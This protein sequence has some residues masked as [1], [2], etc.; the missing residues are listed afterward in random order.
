MRLVML[1]DTHTMHDQVK[2]P[3]GDVI[4][5]AGDLTYAGKRSQWVSALEWLGNLPHK[6][7]IYI[8]GNHDF[9][10]DHFC[11]S[12]G[13]IYYLNN[14]GVTI[15]GHTFWGS[16]I[17]PTFGRWAHMCD[18]EIIDE[19]WDMIPANTEV[20]ITHGPPWGM[21]DESGLPYSRGHL[22]CETLHDAVF[23]RVRP[24]I[25]VF[26]H[27]HGGYG[28]KER[29]DGES[30]PEFYNASVT[31]EAYEVVNKPWVVDL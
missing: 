19:Y 1:S 10:S 28:R 14:S 21:L 26:G 4:I 15:E 6:H 30:G 18:P 8:A 24:K 13:N 16:P 7:K 9:A 2:V 31:N 25:H 12:V 5:H 27:I 17:T 22:G 3:D 29:S 20:L 11:R 23:E